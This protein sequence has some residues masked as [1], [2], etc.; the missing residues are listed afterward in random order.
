MCER[1]M[2]CIISSRANGE[3]VGVIEDHLS[4]MPGKLKFRVAFDDEFVLI[5]STVIAFKSY[6]TLFGFFRRWNGSRAAACDWWP[7]TCDHV[8][9]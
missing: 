3:F 8:R 6:L 4:A 1:Y 2:L 7:D 9:Q 5:A